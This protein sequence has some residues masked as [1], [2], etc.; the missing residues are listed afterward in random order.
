MRKWLSIYMALMILIQPTVPGYAALPPANDKPPIPSSDSEAVVTSDT[1]D[2][3]TSTLP[4]SDGSTSPNASS[5]DIANFLGGGDSESLTDAI[6]PTPTPEGS[7][8]APEATSEPVVSTPPVEPSPIGDILGGREPETEPS[9]VAEVLYNSP[10]FQAILLDPV[11]ALYE[12][13]ND[14]QRQVTGIKI[15][16]DCAPAGSDGGVGSKCDLVLQGTNQRIRLFDTADSRSSAFQLN[17]DGIRSL[18]I[19]VPSDMSLYS[20]RDRITQLSVELFQNSSK[21]SKLM[22]KTDDQALIS[23]LFPP[24]IAPSPQASARPSV[25]ALYESP[26]MGGVRL[27]EFLGTPATAFKFQRNGEQSQTEIGRASCRERVYVLV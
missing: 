18:A 10:N 8:T 16:G 21:L 9:P 2:S 11:S 4:D 24:D 1:A 22:L 3:Q 14:G 6:E 26:S 7:S 19:S 25:A 13:P 5:A 20:G 15:E 17:S 27:A 23:I 12:P